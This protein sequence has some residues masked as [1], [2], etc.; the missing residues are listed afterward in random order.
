VTT[1][2]FTRDLPLWEVASARNHVFFDL[3]VELSAIHNHLTI[4]FRSISP[5]MRL[6][7]S[8]GKD[9]L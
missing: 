2:A 7:R 4:E 3:S 8:D 6:V 5:H 9:P 1:G